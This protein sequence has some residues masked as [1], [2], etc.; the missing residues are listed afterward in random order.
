LQKNGP[1]LS[2]FQVS[3]EKEDFHEI[4]KSTT[5]FIAFNKACD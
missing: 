1:L 5:K 3:S 4:E 2:M